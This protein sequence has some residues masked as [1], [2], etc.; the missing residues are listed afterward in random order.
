ME[1]P[2]MFKRKFKA[3]WS[4]IMPFY[5]KLYNTTLLM[6]NPLANYSIKEALDELSKSSSSTDS[7]AS[8]TGSSTADSTGNTHSVSDSDSNASDYPQQPIA[9][10]DFLAGATTSNTD[11]TTDS[12][13]KVTSSDSSN[14]TG[15]TTAS[16]ENS[17]D[18]TKTIEGI[19]GTT[20]PELIQKHREALMRINDMIIEEMKKCFILVF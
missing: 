14:S 20:Y 19:T 13:G 3:R 17:T 10:G 15:K 1:T 12:T 11:S 9:G 16:S 8:N 5:N 6:Y 18:Y 2:D 4:R 7:T